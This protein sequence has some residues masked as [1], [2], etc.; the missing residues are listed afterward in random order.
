[1]KWSKYNYLLNSQKF[2]LF[3]YN[4][5][6]RSFLKL[7]EELFLICK[8]IENNYN[9]IELLNENVKEEFINSK[10]LISEYEEA[11]FLVKAEYLKRLSS[12][13]QKQLGLV[14]A[15][16]YT[17]N[18]ACPYCYEDNLPNINMSEQVE[19]NIISFINNF[20]EIKE[21]VLCWHGGEPLLR[22]NNIKSLIHKINTNCEAKIVNHDL[23]TNGYLLDK[24]KSEFF[25]ESKLNSI[26]ITIDG[27]KE[28]HDKNRIHKQGKPTFDKIIENI[29][30]FCNIHSECIVNL[31][32]NVHEGNSH[33]YAQ[34][35]K[36]LSEKWADKKV[37]VYFMYVQ[38]HGQC[39]VACL[40]NK[41]KLKFIIELYKKHKLI[42]RS[43]YPHQTLGGCTADS[44]LSFVIGPKGEMYKCWVD[45]GKPEYEIGNIT[46]T[47][48]NLELVSEYVIGTDK[49]S[50]SKCQNCFLLPVCDGGCGKYRLDFKK[51]GVN[52]NVCPIN[53]EDFDLLLEAFYEQKINK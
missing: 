28:T 26:Q 8:E 19:N 53:P 7:N 24:E 40:E 22:Y 44:N 10:I 6:T 15:P 3:V 20:K 51:D 52:Y 1:M 18:F 21:I 2:G 17:C 32:V 35:K 34:L 37:N 16:T 33:E 46:E 4:S 49:F 14:V 47:K 42:E 25:K 48:L 27:L 43:F 12:F 29:D 45:M 39:Q 5:T 30:V 38:A 13:S 41:D 36:E 50:D 11:N 23:V 31:R 9:K